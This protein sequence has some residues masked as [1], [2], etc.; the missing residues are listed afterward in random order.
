MNHETTERNRTQLEF[1]YHSAHPLKSLMH[2][3]EGQH[4][5]LVAAI[6]LFAIK[7]SPVWVLPI[8]IARMIN[9]ISDTGRYSI[10]DLWVVGAIFFVII[11]QN[12]PTHT[13]YVRIFSSALNTMQ[14]NLRSSIVRRLQELS[15][16]FH[17]RNQSG[18][19]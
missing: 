17:D 8:I 6:T 11:I 4:L 9:I 13:A 7:N 12:I 16:S 19:L 1:S 18:K 10:H 14:L 15:I 3:Y 5:K 2:L